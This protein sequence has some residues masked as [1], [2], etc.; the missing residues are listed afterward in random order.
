MRTIIAKFEI[1]DND[2]IEQKLF[3]SLQCHSLKDFRSL[4]DTRE[5]YSTDKTFKSLVDAKIKAQKAIDEYLNKIG[6]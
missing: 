3:D 5:L 1:E 6:F 4:K 2:I